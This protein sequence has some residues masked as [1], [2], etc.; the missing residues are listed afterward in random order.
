MIPDLYDPAVVAGCAARLGALTPAT[1]PQWGKMNA[2]QMLAHCNVAYEMVYGEGGHRKPNAFARLLLWLLIKPAAVSEKPY[3]R[4]AR[5]G[6]QFVI[7]DERDFE[8]ERQRLIAY[9]ERSCGHGAAWFEGRVSDSF[10][11]LTA[12]QWNNLLGK[13]L[14][15]HL[16]Q[17]GV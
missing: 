13:H 16:T 4:H 12:T 8:R 15:H 1:R 6:P 11:P 2:T 10:G 14:E 5:T 3:P 17:F 9:L 7:T